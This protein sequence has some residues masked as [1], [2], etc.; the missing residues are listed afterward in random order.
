MRATATGLATAAVL[1]LAGS[2]AHADPFF[3]CPQPCVPCN[4]IHY[5]LGGC[6]CWYG[7]NYC[8]Q[9]PCLPGQP[10]GG[11]LPLPKEYEKGLPP[12]YAGG[13][14]RYPPGMPGMPGMPG[15]RGMPPGVQP[16]SGM[17][18]YAPPPPVAGPAV[19]STHPFARSPR[20]YFMIGQQYND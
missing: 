6:G 13:P 3:G 7:P 14:G 1:A 10:F 9:G 12:G 20:D 19:F 18:G 11:V 15:Q 2:M 16:L 8:F 17:P 5:T 4:P